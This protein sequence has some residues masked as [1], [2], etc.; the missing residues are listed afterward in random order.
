MEKKQKAYLFCKTV[1]GVCGHRSGEG[2]QQDHTLCREPYFVKNAQTLGIGKFELII[3]KN[4][5]F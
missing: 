5:Q 2:R 4:E 3:N 1:A